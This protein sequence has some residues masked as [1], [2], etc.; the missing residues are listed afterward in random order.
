M[1]MLIT[2]HQ[3]EK[4]DIKSHI[5]Y[6]PLT[7]LN[8]YAQKSTIRINQNI[9]ERFPWE[10]GLWAIFNFVLNIFVF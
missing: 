2:K 4:E 5:Q 8:R 7:F 3:E 6:N 9:N 1:E 10:V